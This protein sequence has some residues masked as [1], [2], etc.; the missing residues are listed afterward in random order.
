MPNWVTNFVICK[1]ELLDKILDAD[2]N[3]DFSILVPEPATKEELLKNYGVRYLDTI[4]ENGRS[5][6]AITHNDGKEWFDWYNWHCDFWGCKWNESGGYVHRE[7]GYAY[8]SFDTA[9]SPPD[10]WIEKLATLDVPFIHH[11]CEEQGFGACKGYNG[12]DDIEYDWD[13]YEYDENDEIIDDEARELPCLKDLKSFFGD[14][15]EPEHDEEP[16]I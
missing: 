7:D 2:G 3:V 4:D 10:S 6:R 1:E 9:W 5:S 16:D 15:P 13:Y 12:L 14:N 11:W 8:V